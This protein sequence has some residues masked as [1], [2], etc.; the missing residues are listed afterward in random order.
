MIVRTLL[1]NRGDA[2]GPVEG[3][4]SPSRLTFQTILLHLSIWPELHESTSPHSWKP[5]SSETWRQRSQVKVFI[6]RRFI[7]NTKRKCQKKEKNIENQSER[8]SPSAPSMTWVFLPDTLTAHWL[9]ALQT[10]FGPA[11]DEHPTPCSRQCR[12]GQMD[13]T[14]YWR[15]NGWIHDNILTQ[16]APHTRG[17]SSDVRTVK[18]IL[19]F[20][21]WF[22]KVAGKKRHKLLKT[23]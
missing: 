19:Y 21:L 17:N 7:R 11:V 4:K 12:A 3:L 8:R 9:K 2:I 18:D 10:G 13:F 14:S 16:S 6:R 23:L 1:T 15:L 5:P 22:W 20:L